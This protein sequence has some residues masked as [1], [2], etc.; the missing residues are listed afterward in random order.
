MFLSGILKS[1][2]PSVYKISVF[3]KALVGVLGVLSHI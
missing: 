3:V 2:G 1:T